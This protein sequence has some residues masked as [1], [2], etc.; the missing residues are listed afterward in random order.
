[1]IEL[2]VNI[3]LFVLFMGVVAG[4]LSQTLRIVREYQR[5]VVFRLGKCI[6]NRG[7]GLVLLIPFIDRAVWVDLRELFIEV[8]H[9]ACITQDNVP[10]KIDFL[11]YRQVMDPVASVVAVTDFGGASQGIATTSLRALIGDILLDDVLA[12]RERINETLRRKLDEVTER[13]GVKVTA[14]E[15]R[16]IVPPNDVQVSMNRQMAAER[17][18]RAA[19]TEAEGQRQAAITV[20]EGERQSQILRAEGEKQ[21]SILKAEGYARALQTISGI[22]QTVDPKTMTLQVI[23]GLKGLGAS[24]GSTF[25]IPMEFTRLLG[26]IG[27]YLDLSMQ[28]KAGMADPSLNGTRADQTD[29]GAP[30]RALTTG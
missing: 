25:V 16:E 18:R 23:D 29:A 17:T 2:A 10:V 30:D 14:V 1:M 19:V 27:D 5:L 20:A 8:P 15:I 21:A 4:V 28:S 7:P 3:V 9:Q 13:W 6:G 24:P 11:I 26:Q 22:A 12:Q